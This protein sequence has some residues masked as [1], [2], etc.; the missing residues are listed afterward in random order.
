MVEKVDLPHGAPG[1]TLG[2]TRELIPAMILA[3][4]LSRRMGGGDKGLLHL[5]DRTVL[6]HVVARVGPQVS[7]MALNANG[8]AA[9]FAA[10]AL[11]VVADPVPGFIGPL[12]GIL[13]AIS[14]AGGQSTHVL[15]VP[16]DTPFLPRDLA[17]RLRSAIRD[18][19]DSAI[20][21]REGRRHPV[22]GLWPVACRG[23]LSAAIE[24][25][26]LRKVETWTDRMN[27]RVVSFDG[28]SFDPFF[29][30]NTPDDL[31]VAR[32]LLALNA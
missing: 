30:V 32:G 7:A 10:L 13:A 29:N 23:R 19:G 5:G 20:A 18:P 22:I 24:S 9:R 4:G 25:E 21:A 27:A 17:L 11:D 31:A 1:T 26:G 12:A 16:S 3:G 28:G 15:T 14:W 6:G 2:T 8:D